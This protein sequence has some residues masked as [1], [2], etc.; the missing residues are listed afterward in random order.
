VLVGAT[1][2]ARKG[3]S[4]DRAAALFSEVD[5]DWLSHRVR[6]GLSSSEGL[7]YQMRDRTGEDPGE[8]DK[9]FLLL[10]SEWA[11][12]LKQAERKGNTASEYLRNFWD[13]LPVVG[14]LTVDNPRTV[15]GGHVSLIGHIT[16][17]ELT[18][19][20]DT[21]E[22]ANGF[23]NRHLLVCVKRSKLLAFGGRVPETAAAALRD[24]LAAAAGFA[25]NVGEVLL[26]EAAARMW[27]GTDGDG[28]Y[29]VLEEDRPGLVGAVT[30]RSSAHVRR[31]A[32]IY[33]LAEFSEVVRPAHLLAAAAVWDYCDR[34]AA[35][36][37]GDK[38]GDQTADA[39]L[40]MLAAAPHGLTR[41]ELVNNFGR[42]VSGERLSAALARVE[43]AGRARKVAVTD[44][45]GR[46]AERWLLVEAAESA[47]S[48][49]MERARDLF[50]ECE[51][52]EQSEERGWATAQRDL[53]RFPRFARTVESPPP[54]EKSPAS[55]DAPPPRPRVPDTV[56]VWLVHELW[57]R[58]K[59]VSE[60]EA[61]AKEA[62]VAGWK[63]YQK[64]LGITPCE[65]GPGKWEWA[66]PAGFN[67]DLYPKPRAKPAGE[68]SKKRVRG[69]GRARKARTA[70]P[71]AAGKKNSKPV[72]PTGNPTT[73][74]VAFEAL[75]VQAGWAWA[76][77]VGW[78]GS[79]DEYV[80]GD[81][82][83]GDLTG[84]QVHR[85]VDHLAAI[86][87]GQEVRR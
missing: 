33:A 17:H 68:K 51:E 65:V 31:L 66:L 42:H 39:V 34:S 8:P 18:R 40:D 38:T 48:K 52:S 86:V 74:S 55:V 36:L 12:V 11:S 61:R 32:M 3:T 28:L 58:A 50:R 23:V 29:H 59:E 53:S 7:M 70:K 73:D 64:V 83:F 10:E 37:F 6:G 1:A 46:P 9:R 24:G 67:Y 56:E 69:V 85:V 4:K 35:Y 62:A 80:P 13:G 21:T 84:P 30:A 75:L 78:L 43:K 47:G 5:P 49:L 19:T 76:S 14:S 20:L 45:G 72:K 2:R 60:L 26:S 87:N 63:K 81:A 57:Q 44:T 71:L 54:E 27:G 79:I 15:T 82:R 77:V 22:M 41:T 25:Q 16:A